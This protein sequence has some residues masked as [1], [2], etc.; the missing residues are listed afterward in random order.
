MC[1]YRPPVCRCLGLGVVRGVDPKNRLAYII[2]DLT[3]SEI[4]QVNC[5]IRGDT[6][7]PDVLLGDKESVSL[8]ECPQ[9][10]SVKDEIFFQTTDS[11]IKSCR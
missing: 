4:E 5:L 10:K 9:I 11:I 2:S 3:S 1:L 8:I 7:L 6:S